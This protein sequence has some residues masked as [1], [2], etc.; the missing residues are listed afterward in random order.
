MKEI[1]VLLVSL[2]NYGVLLC[3][4]VDGILIFGIDMENVKEKKK[5]FLDSKIDIEGS[6]QNEYDFENQ[7]H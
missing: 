5:K 7:D 6:W 3:P 1:F 4:Y 2:K